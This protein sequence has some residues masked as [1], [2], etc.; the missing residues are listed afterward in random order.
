MAM[1]NCLDRFP[2]GPP[3]GG[4]SRSPLLQFC[5]EVGWVDIWRRWHPG[6]RQYSCHSRTLATLSRIDLVLCNEEAL[7]VM[8]GMDYDPRGLSDHSPVIF[9][10]K[11]GWCVGRGEWKL[12]PFWL[13]VIEDDGGIVSD[14][15]EFIKLNQGSAPLGITWDALKAYLRGVLIQKISYVKRKAQIKEHR[16]R[17]KVGEVE[18]RYLEEPTTARYE[19]WV[20]GQEEYR[21]LALKKAEKS[22]MFQKQTFFL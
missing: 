5:E 9:S 1:S 15:K 20:E 14:L 8:N 16:I 21:K 4:A 13:E 17:E 12:N 7:K 10:V 3:P 22:K 6:E 19:A 18:D 11:T 2:T